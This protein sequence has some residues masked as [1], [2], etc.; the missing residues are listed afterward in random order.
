MSQSENF[1]FLEKGLTKYWDFT[2]LLITSK[3]EKE[4]KRDLETKGLRNKGTEKETE[5]KKKQI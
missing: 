2:N 4:K 3:K 1:L 5:K